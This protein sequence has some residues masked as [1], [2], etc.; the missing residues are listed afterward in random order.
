MPPRTRRSAAIAAAALVADLQ[1]METDEESE[2]QIDIDEDQELDEIEDDDAEAEEDAE[3]D[4][5]DEPMVRYHN[6]FGIFQTFS[7]GLG[8]QTSQGAV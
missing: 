2:E 7:L 8:R 3:G 1:Q 6:E 4:V 5:D